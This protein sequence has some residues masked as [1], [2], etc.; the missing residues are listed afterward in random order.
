MAR[1]KDP[2]VQSAFA[3]HLD[4]GETLQSWAYGVKQPSMLLM[5]PLFALAILPGAIAVALLTKEYLVGLTDRRVLVLR[6]KGGKA[7][8]QEVT[9]Y[10]LDERHAAE[11]KAGKLFAHLTVEDPARPFQAKFHRL[12]A[13][14]NHDHA[15][16]AARA[17][18][19]S[20]A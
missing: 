14:N 15:L 4:S 9:A 12:G 10:S 5:I 19:A 8:V 3:P 20:V 11:A 18:G 2:V 7:D 16:A 6:V 13:P 1:Y 17:L